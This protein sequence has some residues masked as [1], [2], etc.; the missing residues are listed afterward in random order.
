MAERRDISL[1]ISDLE[2]GKQLGTPACIL[3]G[4]G[5]SVSAGIPLAEGFVEAIRTEFPE[6]YEEADEKTYAR[7]MAQLPDTERRSLI[8]RYT[9]EARV[10]WAYIAIALMIREGYIGRVFTTNFD[11]LLTRACGMVYASPTVYDLA[12]CQQFRPIPLSDSAIFYLHGQGNG[13]V[14]LGSEEEVQQHNKRLGS[15]MTDA[16]EGRTWLVVGYGGENDP[17]LD[18]LA[19]IPEFDNHLYWVS[20]QSNA[21]PEYVRDKVLTKQ[22]TFSVRGGD[23]SFDADHFFVSLAQKLGIFPPLFIGEP[24]DYLKETLEQLTPYRSFG[25]DNSEEDITAPARKVIRRATE[26]IRTT[27]VSIAAEAQ[28][29]LM[30]G[31]YQGVIDA[32]A[33]KYKDHP[34]ADLGDLL[35]IAYLRRGEEIADV[36]LGQ[37]GKEA[38]ELLD[39][40]CTRYEM[41]LKIKRNLHEA[42]TKWGLA[43]V[44]MAKGAAGNKADSLFQE[45]CKKFASATQTRTDNHEALYKWGLT[46]AEMAKSKNGTEAD[47]L[48]RDAC[49]KFDQVVHIK[50]DHHE[51]YYRWGLVLSDM[52]K[53]KKSPAADTF[54]REACDKFQR[55]LQI[56]PTKHE[57]LNNWGNTL[58]RLGNTRNADE[59]GTLL[60]EACAKYEQ[61]AQIMPNDHEA[62]YNWGVALSELAKIND[63]EETEAFAREACQK[64]DQT[65]KLA[66]DKHEAFNNW[67][68]T[69]SDLARTR[70][71]EEA[72]RLFEEACRQYEQAV[73]IKPDKHETLNNWGTAL[74]YQAQSKDASTAERLLMAAENKCLRAE[75][76]LHG[77]SAYNLACIHAIRQDA[78]GCQYWLKVAKEANTLPSP[79]HVRRDPDLKVFHE[80]TWLEEVLA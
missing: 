26:M 78:E 38:A 61:A 28:G 15:V 51:A 11:S 32:F 60:R 39:Q 42:F 50:A 53:T 73:Q 36:A 31:D 44:S 54:A 72:D 17:V 80:A 30:G 29:L 71:G 79:D 20:Y 13:F 16:G 70:Q 18:R 41:A 25:N 4:A 49:R 7:C 46:L 35:A 47:A 22:G 52:V 55:A 43:L 65:I 40:A 59:A 48:S 6:L 8:S 27:G 33:S 23:A 68:N 14:Q 34:S 77:S 24:L 64:F 12:A 1:I 3:I 63:G 21:A 75:A 9:A 2:Q 10:N 66:P 74:L 19:E 67:G 69:L 37:A 57:A 62:P 56:L 76:V 45:A 5:C 58:C